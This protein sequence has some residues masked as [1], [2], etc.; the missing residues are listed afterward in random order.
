[1]T[2]NILEFRQPSKLVD[3]KPSKVKIMLWNLDFKAKSLFGKL[4]NKIGCP[5]LIRKVEIDDRILG[6]KIQIRIGCS[7][8]IIS[9]G[10]RDFYFDRL[11][12]KFTGTGCAKCF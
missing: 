5:A 9:I 3:A 11:T 4:L 7:S 10:N 1:M 12:G 6:E 2:A 8:S